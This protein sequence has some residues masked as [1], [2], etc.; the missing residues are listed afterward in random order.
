MTLWVG[1]YFSGGLVVAVGVSILV[2]TALVISYNIL[3]DCA[4]A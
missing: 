4:N 3:L 1:K 2:V